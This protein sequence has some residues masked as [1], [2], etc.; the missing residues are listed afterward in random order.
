M[1]GA[2]KEISLG[3]GKEVKNIK[4]V[5]DEVSESTTAVGLAEIEV[6]KAEVRKP[7]ETTTT[8][9]SEET[10]TPGTGEE[11]TYTINRRRNNNTSY[12]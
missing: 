10:T 2:V 7:E 11:T 12:R 1:M 6:I 9:G 3:E 4:F 5:V 8:P